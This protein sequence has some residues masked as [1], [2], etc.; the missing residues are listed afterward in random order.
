MTLVER[1]TATYWHAAR[2][3]ARGGAHH[4]AFQAARDAA[5]E[6]AMR[7]TRHEIGRAHV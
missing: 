1:L 2:H 7:E 5:E 4:E 6:S 3:L